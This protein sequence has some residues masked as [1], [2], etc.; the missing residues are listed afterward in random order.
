MNSEPCVRFGMRINPKIREKP[1]DNRNSSPPKVMLLTASTSQKVI[2]AVF[3]TSSCQKS[4]AGAFAAPAARLVSGFDRWEGARIDRLLEKLLL[5]VSPEL[6]HV[7]IGLDGLVDQLAVRLFEMADEDLANHVPQVV[8]LDRAAWGIGE[9]DR[10]H[11]GHEGG[12][13]IRFAAGLLQA[14][15]DHHAVDV[16]A[17]AVEARID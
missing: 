16:E 10:L 11:G 15:L 9:R 13:V 2:V 4:T 14:S 1:A 8:E 5:V 17:G 12:L 7:V 6:A 3:P